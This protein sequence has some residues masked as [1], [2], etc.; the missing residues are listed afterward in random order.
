MVLG[1]PNNRPYYYMRHQN[2]DCL[3][4]KN[5]KSVLYRIRTNQDIPECTWIHTQK[6]ESTRLETHLKNNH[7][8]TNVTVD[9]LHHQTL[10]RLRIQTPS[11]SDRYCDTCA[12]KV[13]PK[14][15]LP[16]K[17]CRC[18]VLPNNFCLSN[19]KVFVIFY[20]FI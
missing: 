12:L 20:C 17:Q 6:A 9:I 19:R 7:G 11:T 5:F 4:F 15:E 16:Q 18:L 8:K 2:S 10:F 3:Y 1:R 14:R 13:P